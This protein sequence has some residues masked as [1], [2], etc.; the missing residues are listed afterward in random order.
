VA[1]LTLG[2]AVLTENT[3]STFGSAGECDMGI[4]SVLRL[5]MHVSQIGHSLVT[6][7]TVF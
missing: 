7:L 6:S 3:C 5:Q 1:M 2:Q 4:C